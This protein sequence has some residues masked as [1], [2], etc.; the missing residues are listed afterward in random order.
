MSLFCLGVN[1]SIN[2]I[3]SLAPNSCQCW[4]WAEAGSLRCLQCSGLCFSAR[5]IIYCCVTA[6]FL[7]SNSFLQIRF[8]GFD[9]HCPV[10]FR[11]QNHIQSNKNTAAKCSVVNSKCIPRT[12]YIFCKKSLVYLEISLSSYTEICIQQMTTR[13]GTALALRTELKH[14]AYIQF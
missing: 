4:G 2:L 13:L 14:P 3:S 8:S 7:P 11:F 6:D 5:M 10:A 9:L 12:V 1:P